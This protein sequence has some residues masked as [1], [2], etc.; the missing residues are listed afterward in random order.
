MRARVKKYVVVFAPLLIPIILLS[1]LRVTVNQC[2]LPLLIYLILKNRRG[3]I[4]SNIV[5]FD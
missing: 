1:H 3:F 2:Y 4:L 5:L